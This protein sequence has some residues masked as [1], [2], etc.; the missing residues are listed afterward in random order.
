LLTS[1]SAM[2]STLGL[3]VLFLYIFACAGVELITKDEELATHPDTAWIVEY[4]F[5]T[6]QRIM[7]TLFGFVCADSVSAIYT[8]LILA[9]PILSIYFLLLLIGISVALMNL[10]TAVIV[11]GA[12]EQASQD[13]ELLHHDYHESVKEAIPKLMQI[14]QQH[15]A[16]GNGQLT[17][18]EVKTVPIEA[19]IPG[20]LMT[21]AVSSMEEVFEALDVSGDGNLSQSEFVDG[22]MDIFAKDVPLQTVQMLRMLRNNKEKMELLSEKMELL[23]ESLL[24]RSSSSS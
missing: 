15:D 11:E 14:F 18:C 4:H 17:L 1:G 24:M 23:S 16:D 10:V 12:L 9:R 19:I 22:L 20:E 2:T 13:K 3:L 7:L 5:G 6:L 21:D 8:P